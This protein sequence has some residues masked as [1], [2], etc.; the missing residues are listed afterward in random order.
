PKHTLTVRVTEDQKDLGTTWKEKGN[1]YFEGQSVTVKVFPHE[2][3]A[4]ENWL[5]DGPHGFEMPKPE[6]E[7]G[8][9]ACT[10]TFPMPDGD[11][12]INPVFRIIVYTLRIEID[13]EGLIEVE[14]AV[15]VEKDTPEEDDVPAADEKEDGE[16][17]PRIT[18]YQCVVGQKIHVTATAAEGYRFVRWSVTGLA[19]LAN[20]TQE[21]TDVICPAT[22]FVITAH[23]SSSVHSLTVSS[24]DGG[25]ATSEGTFPLGLESVFPLEAQPS[26]GYVFAGWE[27][28]SPQGRFEDPKAA[29][30]N[31]T[32]PDE[33][34]TV[35]ATFKKGS[36]AL[37]ITASHGGSA[38]GES[39]SYE[40]GKTVTVKAVPLEGYVFSH[41]E[42]EGAS[43][44]I[45]AD[46]NAAETTVT[47]PG[48][49]CTVI[50]TFKL[51][52]NLGAP[53]ATTPHAEEGSSFPWIPLLVIFVLS[54]T[55]IG[56]V[57]L[58]EKSGVSLRY[59]LGKWLGGEE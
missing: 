47:V 44:A 48:R 37:K 29:K 32:M 50:A 27:C 13:G 18:E 25:I 40:M 16:E 22:D 58:K 8:D 5:V 35:T 43:A 55:V 31:F 59:L 46:P 15:P 49:D 9:T 38:E 41:W 34:C 11:L 19:E 39:A 26:A 14:G 53:T 1:E 17:K 42:V 3:I 57:I 30:T 54:L 12:E 56:L 52:T 51:S 36:Y 45:L 10:F 21:D 6:I 23:F 28:S 33:D 24:G 20:A 2:G 7:E 4:F